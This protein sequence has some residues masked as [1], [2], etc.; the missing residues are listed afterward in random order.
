MQYDTK[1]PQQLPLSDIVWTNY[2]LFLQQIIA[3]VDR[4]QVPV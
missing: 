3:T 4:G 2:L 1:L